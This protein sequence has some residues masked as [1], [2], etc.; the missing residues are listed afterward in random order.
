MIYE[1]VVNYI[2]DDRRYRH[3]VRV[4]ADNV[5]E[6]SDKLIAEYGTGSISSPPRLIP[7]T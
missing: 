4:E 1:A 6:A 2:R 3:V 7:E 5:E